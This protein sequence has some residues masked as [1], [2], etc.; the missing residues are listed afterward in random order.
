MAW[1]RTEDGNRAATLG[2]RPAFAV[3]DPA[4]ALREMSFQLGDGNGFLGHI[5]KTSLVIKGND[6][7]GA[8]VRSVPIPVF[9]GLTAL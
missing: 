8:A 5:H 9:L 4:Q 3:L 1:R 7:K 6:V 2:D